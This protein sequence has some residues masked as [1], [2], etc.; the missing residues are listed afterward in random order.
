MRVV[1]I[2]NAGGYWGDDPYAF[3]RQV[4]GE[5]PLDYIT[6]DFLA[7]ITMS[8]LQKQYSRDPQAGYAR[9]FV[10]QIEPLL[11]EIL[12]RRIKIITNAGGVNP[13]ACAAALFAVARARGLPLRVALVE[14]DNITSRVPELCRQG[15]EFKNMETGEEL[16]D[17]VEQVLSANAYFGALPV[18][19]ALKYG[20]DIVLAGRVTDTGITLGALVHEFSWAPDDYDKLSHGIVGGHIIECGAQATGGNF[21]DWPKVPSFVD[22][23]FPIVEYRSDGTFVVT[24]HPDSG[25]LV[26][27]QTIR[28]QLLYE[29]GEFASSFCT[30]WA[31]HRSTSLRM[32]LPT[33]PPSGSSTKARSE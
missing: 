5:I 18:V 27:C 29:M 22:I 33:S 31:I 7:E 10:T 2:A 30:R 6:M 8:I 4:L 16:G 15:I 1:R 26:S 28:E 24:K 14:G 13:A 32:S 3:R 19:E 21:T 12:A 25:G 23:G 20:P 11:G 17:C 9:D